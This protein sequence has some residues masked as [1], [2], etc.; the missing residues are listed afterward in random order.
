ML[1]NPQWQLEV[2]P[3]SPGG[4][5]RQF[6]L[7]PKGVR[8][9]MVTSAA[10]FDPLRT[11]TRL[12]HQVLLCRTGGAVRITFPTMQPV[13]GVAELGPMR[14]LSV[15]SS[16]KTSPSKEGVAPCVAQSRLAASRSLNI[17]SLTNCLDPLD[18]RM[19]HLG[20]GGGCR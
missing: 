10:K 6:V 8:A 16:S 13:R 7:S 18:I 5:E 20:E 4:I 1:G 9:A 11:F 3:P 12:R 19:G 17:E 14:F 15:G 2:Q